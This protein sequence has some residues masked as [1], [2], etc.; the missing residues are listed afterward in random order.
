MV[1]GPDA[2]SPIPAPPRRESG[3]S[4][5]TP[6]GETVALPRSTVAMPD[7]GQGTKTILLVDDDRGFLEGLVAGLDAHPERRF[8]AAYDGREAIEVIEASPVDLVV[9]DLK[10]PGVSGFDL[11]AYLARRQPPIPAIAMFAFASPAVEKDLEALGVRSV[12]EKPIDLW[13]FESCVEAVLSGGQPEAPADPFGPE[14]HAVLQ[15]LREAIRSGLDGEL[16]VRSGQKTGRVFITGGGVGWAYANTTQQTLASLIA[17][18]ASIPME[19][20]LQVV[21]ECRRT[22]QPFGR[23]LNSRGLVDEPALRRHLF[24]HT[25]LGL[26]HILSWE[27]PEAVLLPTKKLSRNNNVRFQLDEILRAAARV[28]DAAPPSEPP[29]GT[30]SEAEATLRGASAAPSTDREPIGAHMQAPQVVKVNL[31]AQ[32]IREA[33]D[34]LRMVDGFIGAAA[35]LA[36]G[37]LVADVSNGEFK[38]AELGA[39]ANDVLLKSQK[40]TDIMGVGR[41]NQIHVTAPKVHVLVRCLNENTDFAANEPGRAHVHAMLILAPDGNIALGKMYLEKVIQQVAELMR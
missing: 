17:S 6:G 22:R 1:G 16:V 41:G 5:S 28:A 2:G 8:V 37:E 26:S 14:A 18:R 19:E 7:A 4:S 13:A 40:T 15:A 10:M 30:P 29:A 24:D 39:L 3:L 38:L 36:T 25:A 27:A 20:L 21:E 12:I 11:L 33:L 31:Q 23:T 34:S 9:T 32:K 35:F